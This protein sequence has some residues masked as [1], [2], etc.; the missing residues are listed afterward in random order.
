M[1]KFR[2]SFDWSLSPTPATIHGL[3]CFFT[4][5]LFWLWFH[6]FSF[7]YSFVLG[8]ICIISDS[9]LAPFV[10]SFLPQPLYFSPFFVIIDHFSRFKCID[11]CVTTQNLFRIIRF[12]CRFSSQLN[13]FVFTCFDQIRF[14]R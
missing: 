6:D 12:K 5:L 13:F 9:G 8:S 11:F 14:T 10:S 3:F 7:V 4:C 2:P 1:W